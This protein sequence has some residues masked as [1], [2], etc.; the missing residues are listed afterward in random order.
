M[1]KELEGIVEEFANK[2]LKA[3]KGSGASSEGTTK[4][5]G[6]SQEKVSETPSKIS[7]GTKDPAE[8]AQELASMGEEL[9]LQLQLN[10]AHADFF[11]MKEG[12]VGEEVLEVGEE[13]IVRMIP[14][15]RFVQC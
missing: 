4:K 11:E 7:L 15:I 2:L 1:S 5:E 13:S 14:G 12:A 6:D 10:E 8:R 9:R 3:L